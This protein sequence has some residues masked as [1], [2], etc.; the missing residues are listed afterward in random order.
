MK[1]MILTVGLPASGKTTWAMGCV[2]ENPDTINVNRDDLRF[3]LFGGYT[4]KPDDENRVTTIQ[5]AII[6]DGFKRGKS[7]IVSDTNLN[8]KFTRQLVDLAIDWGAEVKFEYFTTSVSECVLRDITR[9]RIGQRSVGS[10]V[11]EGMA[12]R[13]K[14]A[15]GMFDDLLTSGVE[16]EPY[17]PDKKLPNAIIVDLDGTVAL[18]NRSPYDYDSLHTDSPNAPIIDIV[19]NERDLGT[20]IL[21]TSGRPDSHYDMTIEWLDKHVGIDPVSDPDYSKLFMRKTGDT[22]MDAIVKGEIFDAKIR[23]N[24]NVLYCLDDRNQV[25]DAWRKMGLTCLQVAPGDF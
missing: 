22:R 12:K 10:D 13:Y 1:Q 20:H 7:V 6:K 15:E 3:M 18:H 16:F 4:G 8:R 21:F 25:V 9:G 17:V 24:Y 11:I 2:A 5:R 23:H 19:N 14:V